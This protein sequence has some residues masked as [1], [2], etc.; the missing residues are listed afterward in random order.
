MGVVSGFSGSEWVV[1]VGQES[2]LSKGSMGGVDKFWKWLVC[3]GQM[4]G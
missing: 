2:E 3:G 4:N 1:Q